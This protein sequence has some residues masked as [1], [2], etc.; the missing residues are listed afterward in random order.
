VKTT[1]VCTLVEEYTDH[2]KLI[3]ISQ[4][5]TYNTN[6]VALTQHVLRT[7]SQLGKV[8][9]MSGYIKRITSEFHLQEN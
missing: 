8:T 5:F 6:N 3:D 7:I 4:T 9:L 2:T 1:N